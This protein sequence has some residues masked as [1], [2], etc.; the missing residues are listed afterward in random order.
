MAFQDFRDVAGSSARARYAVASALADPVAPAISFQEWLFYFCENSGFLP[1][2]G[3]ADF[4]ATRA[5]N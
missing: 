5:D 1:L 3:N 4:A 2:S